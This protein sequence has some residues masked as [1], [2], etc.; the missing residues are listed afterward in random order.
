ML[1]SELIST[2][3]SVHV[4]GRWPPKLILLQQRLEKNKGY[5]QLEWLLGF[6][7]SQGG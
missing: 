2:N 7:K 3:A 5:G 1:I 6:M 4:C